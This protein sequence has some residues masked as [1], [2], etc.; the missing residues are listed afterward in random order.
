MTFNDQQLLNCRIFINNQNGRYSFQK[1]NSP[2]LQ[3]QRCRFHHLLTG[4]MKVEGRLAWQRAWQATSRPR[5]VIKGFCENQLVGPPKN[6]KRPCFHWHHR[7]GI[8]NDTHLS[9]QNMMNM[10]HM[11]ISHATLKSIATI[12]VSRRRAQIMIPC[13]GLHPTLAIH[14]LHTISCTCWLCSED[15]GLQVYSRCAKG[16]HEVYL[17]KL[18]FN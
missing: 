8:H 16:S 14:L 9:I 12:L 6:S 11:K 10:V 17:S 5:H 1:P 7:S 13:M 4:R 2:Q 15:V 18:S 3:C